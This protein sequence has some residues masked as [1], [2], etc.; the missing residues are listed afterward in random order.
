MGYLSPFSTQKN[1]LEILKL[2]IRIRYRA[3]F[4]ERIVTI[5][6]SKLN[7]ET[8]IYTFK[9]Y[10]KLPQDERV[11]VI[12]GR[13]YNMTPAPSLKHQTIVGNLFIL[14]KTAPANKCYIGIAPTD[15][16]LD[17]YNV[18]Q[19]DIFLVCDRTKLKE[20]HVEGAP[21][22]IIEVASKH[23]LIKDK[24]EKRKLYEKFGVKEYIIVFPEEEYLEKY[25]LTDKGYLPPE[26]Y[27]KGER[28]KLYTIELEISVDEVFKGL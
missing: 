6:A 17:D 18:V 7:N 27:T 14:L 15:V 4:G 11:E 10:L 9:D 5:P 3:L 26:V 21:D 23:T 19:P 24:R 20:T 28:F 1:M 2:N 13:I 25:I 12:E 8:K 16:V 22:L